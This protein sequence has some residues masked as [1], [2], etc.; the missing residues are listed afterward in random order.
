MN[1]NWR[2]E[3]LSL[4]LI[5]GMFIASAVAWPNAPDSIPV[6]WGITGEPDRYGGKFEGLLLTPIMAIGLYLML[7]FLP[8]IDPK[9]TN[10][11]RFAGIYRLIRIMMVVFM[12]GIHGVVLAAVFGYDIDIGMTIMIMAGLLLAVLGNY[13][14]KM[15]PTWFVGIRTPWTLTSDRSWDRTHRLGGRLFVILGLLLAGAGVIGQEWAFYT[16]FGL[17]FVM[18]IF[19]VVYSYLIWEADPDRR[20][21][22][23]G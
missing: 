17:L 2:I 16:V 6:H 12:A 11:Q 10:Y 7:L 20:N 23:G 22:L 13:F 9:R 19:L 8:R 14:G 3:W 4:A 5:A 15:K 18:I 21:G 1:V